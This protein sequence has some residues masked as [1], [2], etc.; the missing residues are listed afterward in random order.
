[1]NQSAV[2][3]MLTLAQLK[4]K[5]ESGE[6]ET[7]VTVFPD[8]YGR[9]VGKRITTDFFMESVA[10]TGMHACDYLFTVDMD[11]EPIPGYRFANWET[12][13][14]DFHC[15]PDPDAMRMATWLDKSALVMCD[16]VDEN[17][18]LVPESPRGILKNQLAAAEAMGYSAKGASELE[19]FIFKDSYTE[20]R[21]RAYHDLETMS[22]YI[23]DYHIFQ[24]R[25]EEPLNA[26]ARKHLSNSGVPVEFSKG[27]WGPGQHELNIRYAPLL[28]MADRHTVY[29]QCFKDLADELGWSVTFMA[30]FHEKLAG[31]SCHM[32]VSLWD[33]DGNKPI[34]PGDKQIGPVMGSDQFRWFLGGW[35]KHVSD[36]MPFYAPTVNSYK[37]YKA[38]SWAPTG[39]AWSYDNRTAGFRVVGSGPSLRIESR[40][41]GADV[42]PY[43]GYAAVLA[44]GL[45]GIENRIEPP[46]IFQGDVYTAAN[47]PH[48]PKTFGRAV[49]CFEK[50]EFARKAF[51][52]AV[53]EHYLHFFKTELH[54]YE[55]AV[56]D[57]ERKRYFEQI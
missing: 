49:D 7:V 1:M 39:I 45:D 30:K 32:H 43:L 10:G 41:A 47:L 15:V 17:H 48:V 6:V 31:S 25:R 46:P 57:W 3:G 8:L 12:G 5:I 50:S 14:G 55:N 42:N 11:M 13:Y 37:R 2:R 54:A 56:T 22:G 44:S 38:G 27:E 24:G 33:K 20:A 9:L 53:V 21:K 23:E 40:V 28:Q 18:K 26:A 36:L 29:K 19:Y 51:G 52:E 4:E 35:M 34:F 16:I